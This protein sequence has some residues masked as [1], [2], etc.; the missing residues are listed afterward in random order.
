VRGAGIL[1]VMP[2]PPRENVPGTYHVVGEGVSSRALFSGGETRRVFLA[3][4]NGAYERYSLSV[5]AYCLLSTHYHLI[6]QTTEA[7]LSRSMQWLNS[8]YAERINAEARERG[9]LFGARFWSRRIT[10]DPDLLATTRYIA[11]NPVK[12]EICR[13]AEQWPWSS[14]SIFVRGLRRPPFFDP[15]LILSLFGARED[16]ALR[17]LRAYVEDGLTAAP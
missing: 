4:V 16:V 1:R 13:S 17:R 14:Y 11:L 9:H 5:T 3:L 10:S 7:D 15:S 2:R 8:R 12:A 6:V